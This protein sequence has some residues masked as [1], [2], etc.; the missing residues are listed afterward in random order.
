MNHR[1]TVGQLSREQPVQHWSQKVMVIGTLSQ[2]GEM[3]E[4][5]R[6]GYICTPQEVYSRAPQEVGSKMEHWQMARLPLLD[7]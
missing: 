3:L 4:G 5:G 2:T 1:S 7:Q 6:G